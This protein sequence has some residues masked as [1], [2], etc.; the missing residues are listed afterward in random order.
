M[1]T[2]QKKYFLIRLADLSHKLI[3]YKIKLS[4]G[5]LY[6]I[7]KESTQVEVLK[8]QKAF[9]SFFIKISNRHIE[10]ILTYDLFLKERNSFYI[11]YTQVVGNI[12]EVVINYTYQ[13][14]V[15]YY[16]IFYDIY[17]Q[18]F[19][20]FIKRVLDEIAVFESYIL[21]EDSIIKGANINSISI[22]VLK[23]NIEKTEKNYIKY[24]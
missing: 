9:I 1:N 2:K 8:E 19:F 14:E 5:A 11:L 17:V 13:G 7:I 21:T 22:Y 18:N 15:Q 6:K 20:I 12:C 10:C 3:V 4:S 24:I 16:Y 23:T